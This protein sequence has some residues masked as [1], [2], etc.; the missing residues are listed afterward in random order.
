M[1]IH[2]K[3]PFI[4]TETRYDADMVVLWLVIIPI[5]KRAGIQGHGIKPMT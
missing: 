4:R 5:L 1:P 3:Y 2:T